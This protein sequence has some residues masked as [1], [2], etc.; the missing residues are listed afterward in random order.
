MFG[1]FKNPTHADFP[2]LE[3]LRLEQD[4][5]NKMRADKL[6][7]AAISTQWLGAQ[8]LYAQGGLLG[9]GQ[10]LGGS[11]LSNYASGIAGGGGG[12]AG[13][14]PAVTALLQARENLS[15]MM[16]SNFFSAYPEFENWDVSEL[17]TFWQT[18]FG[19]CYDYLIH[20]RPLSSFSEDEIMFAYLSCYLLYKEML[21]PKI[22]PATAAVIFTRCEVAEDD[23]DR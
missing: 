17:M 19:S 2:D 11:G 12:A 6:R 22:D 13:I 20:K 21:I 4:S 16:A 18:R 3:Q 15:E 1:F 23:G 9:A 8:G 14:S 7:A 5:L 10:A